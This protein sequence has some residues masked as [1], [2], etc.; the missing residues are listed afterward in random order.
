MY[1]KKN[2]VH[3][4]KSFEYLCSQRKSA[5]DLKKSLESVVIPI[6]C[7]AHTVADDD[8]KAKLSKV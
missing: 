2:T 3:C 5:E 7:S 4:I 8:K 6:F 1:L